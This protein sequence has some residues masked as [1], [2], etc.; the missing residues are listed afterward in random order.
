MQG[1]IR[2]KPGKKA[3]RQAL[4]RCQDAAYTTSPRLHESNYLRSTHITIATEKLSKIKIFY[5]RFFQER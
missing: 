3:Y 2:G 4:P 5:P 1:G